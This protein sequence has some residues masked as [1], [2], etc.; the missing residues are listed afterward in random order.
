MVVV[1][2]TGA[3]GFFAAAKAS[4]GLPSTGADVTGLLAGVETAGLLATAAGATGWLAT[5]TG[6]AGSLGAGVV[7]LAEM[8]VGFLVVLLID[9]TGFR[10]SLG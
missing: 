10:F 7:T 9:F 4:M 8:G 5:I 3:T 2:R 1:A 6:A